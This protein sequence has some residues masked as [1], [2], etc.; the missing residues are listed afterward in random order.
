MEKQSVRGGVE[1]AQVS[2]EQR[3]K[4]Q[5]MKL[6]KLGSGDSEVN[7]AV[8]PWRVL[9]TAKG[10]LFTSAREEGTIGWCP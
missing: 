9:Y 3:G 1:R 7:E 6:G 10:I 2:L 4:L 5:G 8:V